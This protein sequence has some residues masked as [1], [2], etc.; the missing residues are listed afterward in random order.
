MDY[1]KPLFV[2]NS[3]HLIQNTHPHPQSLPLAGLSQP[4]QTKPNPEAEI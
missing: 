1:A 3:T 2:N 4:N